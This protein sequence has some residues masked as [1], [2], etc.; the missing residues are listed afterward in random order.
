MARSVV[1]EDRAWKEASSIMLHVGLDLSRKRLDI[2][3]ISDQGELV[4]ELAAPF[5]EEG[6]CRL[7]ERMAEK[8]AGRVHAVVESMNGARFVHDTLEAQWWDVLVADE[9]Q[10]SRR[11]PT[12]RLLSERTG[13]LAE[14]P[15]LEE[16]QVRA[17]RPAP[18]LLARRPVEEAEVRR[19]P[20]WA[21]ACVPLQVCETKLVDSR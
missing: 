18:L 13:T 1:T 14:P 11:T 9:T 19:A 5:D 2:C 3:A 10:A 16:G 21:T 15:G 4:D 17:S 12:A 20:A 8:H 7:S 6:L